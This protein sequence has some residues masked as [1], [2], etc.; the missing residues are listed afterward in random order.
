MADS[1]ENIVLR[2]QQQNQIIEQYRTFIY[3]LELRQNLFIKML[4]EKGICAVGEFEKRWPLYLRNDV[5]VLG[6][7]GLML[8]ELKISVFGEDK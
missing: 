6:Q 2:L 8:G 7:D 3:T 5:G 4:E 1:I